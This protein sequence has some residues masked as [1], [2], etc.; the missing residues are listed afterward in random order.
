MTIYISKKN[1][2]TISL[3]ILPGVFPFRFL[4]KHKKF[5]FLLWNGNIFHWIVEISF[6]CLPIKVIICCLIFEIFQNEDKECP[7]PQF[8]SELCHCALEMVLL[9]VF[10]WKLYHFQNKEL[11]YWNAKSKYVLFHVK[12]FRHTK[13][14]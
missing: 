13:T 6:S 4:Y 8:K 5:V 9:V 14:K 12:W 1:S 10:N 3:R 7:H 2:S 11:S